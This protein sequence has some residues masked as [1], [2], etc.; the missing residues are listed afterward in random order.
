MPQE[1]L[2]II[3]PHLTLPGGA[4]KV[5]LELGKRLAKKNRVYFVAQKIEE[6]YRKDYPEIHFVDLNGP[7]TDRFAFWA[8]FPFWYIKTARAINKIRREGKTSILCNVF[9]ANWTGL[10][11]KVLH[12]E[13]PCFWFCHEPSAFI[14]VKKWRDAIRSPLKR[15]IANAL[16]P[17]FSIIDKKLVS[18]ADKIFVNSKYSALSAEQVYQRKSIIIY[19]GVDTT[20]FS[21]GEFEKKEKI[22]LSVGHLSKF[23]NMDMLIDAFSRI[24]L[25]D[26]RLILIGD[27]EEKDRLSQRI[28][29]LHLEDRA[30]ILSGLSDKEI[31]NIYRRSS[32]FVSCSKEEPFGIVILEAMACGTPVI[33]D[34]SGGPTETVISGET[35]ELIDCNR[36]SLQNTLSSLLSDKDRL[37]RYSQRASQRVI[38]EFSWDKSAESLNREISFQ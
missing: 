24:T 26:A 30:K 11:F 15:S 7:T 16:S 33:A 31:R 10:I 1:N 17:I 37:R 25:K 5:A 14:H 27:G 8:L 19:P 18:R 9:P 28:H 21:P 3:H 34:N 38:S 6:S 2:I 20:F 35:G 23:K 36:E 29:D 13:T 4:G 22:V 12:K 32:V